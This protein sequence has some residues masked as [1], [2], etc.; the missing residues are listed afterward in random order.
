ML[1]L[2]HSLRLAGDFVNYARVNRAWWVL[3]IL[4]LIALALMAVGT[5]HVVVPYT[6]YT[7]F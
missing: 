4:P 3:L 2:R 7:L 1:R 6:V 5:T